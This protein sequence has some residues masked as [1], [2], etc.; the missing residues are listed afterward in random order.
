[1]AAGIDTGTVSDANSGTQIEEARLG[2]AEAGLLSLSAQEEGNAGMYPM[3]GANMRRNREPYQSAGSA[4]MKIAP[5]T[6]NGI[7]LPAMIATTTSER[8]L[9]TRSG[10]NLSE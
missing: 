10:T 2:Q 8:R 9:Q 6:R 4:K 3:V 1:M 7:Q 5:P